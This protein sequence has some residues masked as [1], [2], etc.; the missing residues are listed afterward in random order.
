MTADQYVAMVL[1]KY[2]I[3]RTRAESAA[4]TVAPEIRRWAGEQLSDLTYSG[5]F[6]KGTANNVSTDIDLFIGFEATY[7]DDE[8]KIQISPQEYA[9]AFFFLR[10]LHRL[11]RIGTVPAIDY[12]IYLEAFQ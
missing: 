5:S 9:L 11:Q 3:N 2:E 1:R 7:D 6:A 8:L 4:Q 12:D 10:L